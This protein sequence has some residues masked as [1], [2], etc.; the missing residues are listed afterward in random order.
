MA[1]KHIG[2]TFC[3]RLLNATIVNESLKTTTFD[4]WDCATLFA[5]DCMILNADRGGHHKKANLLAD[6]EGFILIDHELSLHFIDN[7]SE[8]A[9]NVIMNGFK[10]NIWPAIYLKHL[11]YSR[12][13]SYKR[14]KDNLFDTFKE[15]LDRLDINKIS[16]LL[17]EL[18]GYEIST[19]KSNRL[20]EIFMSSNKIRINFVQFC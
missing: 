9:Y 15:Y 1:T 16:N 14:S 7:E 17:I 10:A 2:N 12:L 19:G 11:F 4:I 6:D 5:F 20:I 13:K 8:D 18:G 3:S